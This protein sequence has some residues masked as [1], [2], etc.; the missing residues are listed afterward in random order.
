VVL[1][2]R[3]SPVFP[4]KQNGLCGSSGGPKF[5]GILRALFP[6]NWPNVLGE[7][8]CSYLTN[9]PRQKQHERSN[10]ERVLPF[11]AAIMCHACKQPFC[12]LCGAWDCICGEECCG[13]CPDIDV[14]S[15]CSLAATPTYPKKENFGQPCTT[16]FT[17]C[18]SC[19]NSTF[20]S[21]YACSKC[22]PDFRYAY[23]VCDI[24]RCPSPQ[25]EEGYFPSFDSQD[26]AW[27]N[28]ERR[29]D[30]E[31]FDDSSSLG[32]DSVYVPHLVRQYFDESDYD[33]FDS[34]SSL[35]TQYSASNSLTSSEYFF[36]N[37]VSVGKILRTQKNK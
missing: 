1:V 10:G 18:S 13:Y 20:N 15:I 33:S 21:S 4:T 5:N 32:S 25:Y 8:V 16:R 12:D 36:K 7:E 29:F 30:W 24:C 19:D 14:C 28:W 2:S 23:W 26:E 11:L 37:K 22:I 27:Y 9:C 35:G 6:E 34:Q 17:V 31:Y 3:S